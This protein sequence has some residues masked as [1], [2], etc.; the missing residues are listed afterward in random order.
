MIQF[1]YQYNIWKYMN[2][3]KVIFGDEVR[4]GFLKGVNTIAD[5]VTSTLGPKGQNVLISR[6]YGV[7]NVVHDGVTVANSINI[8]DELSNQ[9]VQLLQDAARQT[10]SETG[11]GTTTTILLTSEIY[12]SGARQISSG[13]NGM[14]MRKGMELALKE[15]LVMLEDHTREVKK[16]E[17]KE[18]ATISAQDSDIGHY[19]AEAFNLT[20]TDGSVQVDFGK[21]D[22]KI[23]IE[24]HKGISFES[25]LVNGSFVTDDSVMSA[26]YEDVRVLITDRQIMSDA[27]LQAIANIVKIEKNPILL[28]AESYNQRILQALT[29]NRIKHGLQIIPVMAPEVGDRKTSLL[30][31]IAVATDAT[32]ISSDSGMKFSDATVS[33]LGYAEKVVVDRN[34]TMITFSEEQVKNE[35]DER[36]KTIQ[37]ELKES[38]SEFEI[39]FLKS[40]IAKLSGGIAVIFVGGKTQVENRELR[41]RVHDAIGATRSAIDGGVI[42]GG[43]TILYRIS[44]QLKKQE[45]IDADEEAGFNI[46]LDALSK[47][48]EKLITNSN[49]DSGRIMEQLDTLYEK[50]D[51]INFGFNAIT[52]NVSDLVADKILDPSKVTRVALENAV[53]TA[54]SL[55]TTSCAVIEIEEEKE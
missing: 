12:K 45:F 28:I 51:E 14:M 10:N 40:R 9:A 23:E 35:V 36:I 46:V 34:S 8:E 22:K 27:D 37:N 26:I 5:A 53:S 21:N 42:I 2:K 24:Y 13:A 6:P 19:I 44:K 16:S 54:G 29:L 17:W 38:Q 32:M 55:I 39:E 20:G 31:D 1:Y 47:P 30:E 18:I 52:G 15:V 48:L 50:D 3:T 41:E 25:G 4:N 11:D 43:G 49:K 7:P 33:D